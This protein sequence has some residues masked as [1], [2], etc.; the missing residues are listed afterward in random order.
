MARGASCSRGAAPAGYRRHRNVA[1][2][3]KHRDCARRSSRRDRN[4][5]L[6][7][8]SQ[9]KALSQNGSLVMVIISPLMLF[10]FVCICRC[11]PCYMLIRKTWG[12]ENYSNYSTEKKTSLPKALREV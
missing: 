6:L 4:V 10:V 3:P 1:Q 11:A 12:C 5:V 2:S 8:T 9:V 7:R